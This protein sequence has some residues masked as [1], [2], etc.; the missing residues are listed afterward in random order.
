MLLVD[1]VI[2]T[3]PV[4]KQCDARQDLQPGTVG[5]AGATVVVAL[6]DSEGLVM[7]C[8]SCAVAADCGLEERV[9]P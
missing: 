1:V 3:G 8:V 2:D 6:D 7:V 5:V 4:G 9:D